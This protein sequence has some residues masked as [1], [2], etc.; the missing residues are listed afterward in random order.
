MTPTPTPKPSKVPVVPTV[1]VKLIG[2][3]LVI[4]AKN[5]V[6]VAHIN[7]KLAKVGKNVVKPGNDLV[8]IEF[9]SRIIYSKVFTI[10]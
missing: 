10:K 6:V 7:G 9:Q 4:S 3:T 2:R 5:G 1:S 8:V